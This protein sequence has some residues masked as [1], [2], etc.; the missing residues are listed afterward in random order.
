MSGET[1]RTDCCAVLL[2]GG[3]SRRIGTDKAAL[4]WKENTT[5][6]QAVARQMDFLPEKYLSVATDGEDLCQRELLTL[7]SGWTVLP[8]RVPNC[9]PMG[10]I[11]TALTAC[12]SEWALVT[13]CDIPAIESTLF[14]RLL[15]DTGSDQYEIIYPVTPDGKKHLTCALYRKR[16]APVLEQQILRGDYRLR[17]L[18]AMC[19]Y[20]E[21]V[22]TD[23]SLIRMLS[24]VNTKEDL[25]RLRKAEI[26]VCMAAEPLSREFPT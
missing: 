7:P 2:R 12:R 26:S 9:G 16:I 18:L 1:N 24:N 10:G 21:V 13:S 8:D 25:R 19:A 20:K 4:L 6:L 23:P 15:E 17:N 3:R 5:F 14:L 11:W 22:I